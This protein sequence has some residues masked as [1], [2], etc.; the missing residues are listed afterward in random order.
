MTAHPPAT[1]GPVPPADPLRTAANLRIFAFVT[2]FTL[3]LAGALA[4]VL[5]EEKRRSGLLIQPEAP[6]A[7]AVELPAKPV[8]PAPAAPAAPAAVSAMRTAGG[9]S[10]SRSSTAS[11]ASV[12]STMPRRWRWTYFCRR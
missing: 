10:P 8:A 1:P 12:P 5:R 11:R 2:V 4:L 9:V 3:L 7:P 6:A